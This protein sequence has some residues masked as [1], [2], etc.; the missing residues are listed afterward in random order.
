MKKMFLLVIT[1]TCLII[2]FGCGNTKNDSVNEEIS[3]EIAG[4]TAADAI[5][6]LLNEEEDIP[7]PGNEIVLTAKELSE[8][9]EY[10]EKAMRRM[11]LLF[12][13]NDGKIKMTE[14]GD[15]L[16][17]FDKDKELQSVL[18]FSTVY[19]LSLNNPTVLKKDANSFASR[20]F[21][22][23]ISKSHD[24]NRYL[25]SGRPN[26]YIYD[27]IGSNKEYELR[28]TSL[29]QLNDGTLM[30]QYGLYEIDYDTG[31]K[32]L[33][34]YWA[35]FS[36]FIEDSNLHVKFIFCEESPQ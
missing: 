36:V 10:I 14:L 12:T 21:G 15:R 17:N 30:F 18:L 11:H 24:I 32:Y 28:S 20:F 2:F 33:G 19:H 31:E 3:E 29:T 22:V 16:P 6:V 8:Q 27:G 25:D 4:E 35:Y 5:E 9:K 23:D 26:E 13:F 7:V 1:F 34:F